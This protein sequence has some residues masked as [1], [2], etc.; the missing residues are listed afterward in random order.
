LARGRS[1]NNRRGIPVLVSQLTSREHGWIMTPETQSIQF[2]HES[3]A[4]LRRRIAA[5]KSPDW[6]RL[7]MIDLSQCVRMPLGKA[8]SFYRCLQE[9][10]H[11]VKA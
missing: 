3:D 6:K 2:W 10:C 8:A 11:V 7:H 1:V 5:S 9:A 4:I